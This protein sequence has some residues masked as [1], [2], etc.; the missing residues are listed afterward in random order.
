MVS[1]I[2]GKVHVKHALANAN[3]LALSFCLRGFVYRVLP[4]TTVSISPDIDGIGHAR[5]CSSLLFL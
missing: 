3:R 1:I 4:G 2:T 5:L